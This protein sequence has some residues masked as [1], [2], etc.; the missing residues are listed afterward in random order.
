[1]KTKT[2]AGMSLAEKFRFIAKLAESGEEFNILS[3]GWNPYK[4]KNGKLTDCGND[5]RD[6]NV[7]QFDIETIQWQPKYGQEFYYLDPTDRIGFKRTIWLDSDLEE[8]LYDRVEL[9]RTIDEVVEEVEKR[10][11]KPMVNNPTREC[12]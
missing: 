11:W 4:F 9:F 3:L 10:G 5:E 7:L 1:M 8:K 6:F 12:K 2:T